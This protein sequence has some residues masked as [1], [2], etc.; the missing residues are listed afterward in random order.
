[1]Y[2]RRDEDLQ[3]EAELAFVIAA[4]AAVMLLALLCAACIAVYGIRLDL[5]F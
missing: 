5:P 1:M 2:D 3:P 4:G